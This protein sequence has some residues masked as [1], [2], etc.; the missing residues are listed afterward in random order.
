M[1]NARFYFLSLPKRKWVGLLLNF[2]LFLCCQNSPQQQVANTE[3]L[4]QEDSH[5]YLWVL[6]DTR[7]LLADSQT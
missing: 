2:L 3:A 4:P 6:G 5:D 1:Q 7:M